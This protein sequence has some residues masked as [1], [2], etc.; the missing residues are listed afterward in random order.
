MPSGTGDRVVAC[1]LINHL[2]SNIKREETK[3]LPS[4]PLYLTDRPNVQAVRPGNSRAKS[5]LLYS[6]I[7]LISARDITRDSMFF[8]HGINL[9]HAG[10]N[11]QVSTRRIGCSRLRIQPA[12]LRFT[13]GFLPQERA[14]DQLP[15][16]GRLT[17]SPEANRTIRGLP[18][19]FQ[20][21]GLLLVLNGQHWHGDAGADRSCPPALKHHRANHR[22][23]SPF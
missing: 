20:P 8:A 6:Y 7:R 23:V 2:F 13:S 14:P 12:D 17:A 1:S 9:I 5:I 16:T 22:A 19:S 15:G 21:E 3:T 4:A 10:F 11:H 18:G